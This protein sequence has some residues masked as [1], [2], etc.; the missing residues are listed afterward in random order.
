MDLNLE[1]SKLKALQAFSDSFIIPFLAVNETSTENKCGILGTGVLFDFN[2]RKFIVTAAHVVSLVLSHEKSIGIPL[3]S[4]TSEVVSLGQCR[5]SIPG[6]DELQDKL[7]IGFLE[8]SQ[9]HIS[10]LSSHYKF[11]SYTNLETRVLNPKILITGYPNTYSVINN[12]SKKIVAKPLRLMTTLLSQEATKLIREKNE[13]CFFTSWNNTYDEFIPGFENTPRK[14]DLG[15][16]SGSPIWQYYEDN[17]LW[18]P[19]KCLKIIGFQCSVKAT[20]WIKG[21]KIGYLCYLFRNYDN[22]IYSKLLNI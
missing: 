11:L 17:T 16:L 5:T 9:E 14:T 8:L 1:S 3:S 22:E 18:S 19:E 4:F 12:K 20:E 15:G 7:D 13:Y 21:I 10:R 2:N 6:N